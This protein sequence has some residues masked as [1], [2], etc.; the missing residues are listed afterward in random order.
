MQNQ[1]ELLGNHQKHE[2]FEKKF[3]QIQLESFRLF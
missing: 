3:N 1:L 2:F